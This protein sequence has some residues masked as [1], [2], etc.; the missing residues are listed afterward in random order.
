MN[1]EFAKKFLGAMGASPHVAAQVIREGKEQEKNG[2][3]LTRYA[4]EIMGLEGDNLVWSM[5][6]AVHQT[7]KTIYD[8]PIIEKKLDII[9]S[10]IRLAVKIDLKQDEE[11]S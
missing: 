7:F 8:D 6:R 3:E 11:K 5:A 9:L 2:E 10:T 1:D 4:R